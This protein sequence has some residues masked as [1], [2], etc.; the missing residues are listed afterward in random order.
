MTLAN[1]IL[2]LGAALQ[3]PPSWTATAESAGNGAV[4]EI[5]SPTEDFWISVGAFGRYSWPFGTVEDRDA[6]IAGNTIL[7]PDHLRYGDLF[8]DGVGF[9]LEASLMIFRPPREQRGANGQAPPKGPYAGLYVA[10]QSDSYEGNRINGGGGFI[11]AG[12]MD[13]YAILAGLKVTTNVDSGLFGE[14]RLGIG[15]VEYDPVSAR[16]SLSGGGE[17]TQELFEE[18]RA[19]AAEFRCRFSARLGPVRLA[20]GL[21]FRYMGGPQEGSGSLGA[22][23]DPGAF[24]SIDLDLGVELGF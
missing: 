7:I 3:S 24:W 6:V 5:Q 21:G 9:S 16:V 23:V 19:F 13:L 10:L 17:D 14:A 1:A 15:V 2:F 8:D 20:G 18:S 22:L 11:D 12:D 4:I